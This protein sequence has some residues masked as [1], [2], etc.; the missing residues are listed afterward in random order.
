MKYLFNL[1]LCTLL[2]SVTCLAE[3]V[4]VIEE[5]K[6][7]L[8]ARI[9]FLM[10]AQKSIDVQYFTIEHDYVSV[11]GLALLK[12]AAKR[13]VKVR[14]IVDSMHNLMTREMMSAFLGNLN[15]EVSKNIEI[16][17][18]NQFNIFRP[19]CYT[20]RMHDK[21]LIID[22]QYLI[23]GDR[24]VANGYYDYP[25]QDARG[26]TL[27]VFQGTDVLLAGGNSVA[28]AKKYFEERWSSKDVKPVRLYNFSVSGLDYSYCT[29]LENPT[30]CEQRRQS[31]IVTIQNEMRKLDIAFDEVM[32][33]HLDVK[34]DSHLNLL[35][36]A[37]E[38]NDVEFIHDDASQRVCKGK[39]PEKNIGKSL[40]EAIW[41]NTE[42]DLIIMT[43]YLV[44]TPEMEALVKRLVEEKG[45]YVRFL[46]NSIKSNDVPA[47]TAGYLKT[48]SRLMNIKNPRTGENSVRIYE[49]HNMV[50]RLGS[51]GVERTSIDT[52]HAKVVLMDSKKAFIGSYNWDYRSQNLNSEVGVI[53][54]LENAK[55]QAETQEIR[56]RMSR[57]LRTSHLVK[58]DG[59]IS[60]EDK[61]GSAFSEDE[62]NAL[63]KIIKSRAAGVKF[64]EKLLNIRVIGDY[65]LEQL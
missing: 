13:G 14:I 45:V 60:G 65:L 55:N 37:Y 36:G 6:E 18:F 39:N 58:E 50:K 4:V 19:F 64:W 24:N 47:A 1:V 29:Y 15:P 10:N 56:D 53:I 7:S 25:D 48:R 20:R 42:K 33:K 12:D 43:P 16:R 63:S 3:K 30:F 51:D 59:S 40:Y 52:L 21:S 9:H 23:V 35:E 32:A 41:Q 34:K 38:T 8:N 62:I 54:G 44:V 61:I 49:Y 17:E 22:E 26:K 11:A 5:A 27:P 28:M 46:T 2:V 31:D 57:V